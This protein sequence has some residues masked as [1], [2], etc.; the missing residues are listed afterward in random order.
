MV[1]LITSRQHKFVKMFIPCWSSRFKVFLCI[2][3]IL[4]P[5]IKENLHIP[6]EHFNR[7]P[8]LCTRQCS[9]LSD[10]VLWHLTAYIMH[11]PTDFK[12]YILQIRST[13]SYQW[14][15]NKH[16][17]VSHIVLLLEFFSGMLYCPSVRKCFSEQQKVFLAN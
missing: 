10:S 11:D 13:F 2:N 6:S 5:C 3:V 7:L 16:L 9:P 12:K 4:T 15:S 14:Q 8:T 17:S 1:S